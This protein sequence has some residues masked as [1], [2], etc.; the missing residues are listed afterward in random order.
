MDLNMSNSVGTS[1]SPV[2]CHFLPSGHVYGLTVV[3]ILSTIIGTIGN[4]LVIG[5]VRTNYPLQIISNFWLVSMAVADLFVTALG[6]PLFTVFLGLQ[7]GGQC[8]ETVSQ[9]FRLIA[10]MSCSASVLHL[11]LISVDRCLVI[12]R[13][14]D[15]RVI[16]TKKRFKFALVIAWTLPVIY[17]VLR[18]TVSKTA[19][20][21]FTVVAVGICYIVIISCYTLIILK[22]RKQGSATLKRIRGPSGRSVASEHM[23]ERRVTVTIAIVVVIFTI[24]WFPLLYLRSAFAEEN[25][26]VAYNWARTLALSNSSMNPWI[27]CFRIAEFREAYRRLLKCQWKPVCRGGTGEQR[28]MNTTHSSDL[29]TTQ[30]GPNAV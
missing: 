2:Q 8:N 10:N 15:F 17:G 9:A 25:F 30:Q 14:H 6:Q 12:L 23:V 18:L 11:C 5:T 7:I 20:S 16:R 21:Y 3:N 13:P 27:Y 1:P 28:D 26:G 22:V 19:T 24:C 29:E 4:V